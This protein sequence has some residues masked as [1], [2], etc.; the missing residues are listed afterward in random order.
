MKRQNKH[1]KNI[2]KKTV[3]PASQVLNILLKCI[4][5]EIRHVSKTP[6]PRRFEDEDAYFNSLYS[7]TKNKTCLSKQS[8]FMLYQLVQ[9]TL[10]VS[11]DVA[12]LGVYKGG[13]AKMTARILQ[14]K[15]SAKTLYLLDTFTGMPPLTN[16]E[17]DSH[18]AGDF[19]DTTIHGVREY[20]KECENVEFVQGLFSH[21][22][23]T[24]TNRKFS[25]VHI[26]ADIYSSMKEACEFFYS[27]LPV[28]AVMLFDDYGSPTCI[29]A[30][31]AVDEFFADKK[32]RPISLFTGQ[33][34]IYK[35]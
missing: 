21:T 30:K 10:S 12:E 28:G 34:F 7:F 23:P 11:G 35:Q 9:L 29:G 3:K 16:E 20:L 25:F 26:D 13:S 24:L 14:D 19:V 5:L 22:L 33:A 15:S 1:W 6:N 17:Y 18:R 31:K 27:K 8:L 4:R 32:E 2:R